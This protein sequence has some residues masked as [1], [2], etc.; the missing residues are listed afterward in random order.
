MDGPN[1][2]PRWVSNSRV[3]L[4]PQNMDTNTHKQQHKRQRTCETE[5]DLELEYGEFW[6]RF[7]VISAAD[8]SSPLR[9][10]PFAVQKGIEGA[11]GKPVNIRKLQSGDLVVEV[12]RKSH[13]MNLLKLPEFVGHKVKCT[14]HMSL[15]YSK[16]ILRCR[17]LADCSEDE[18]L[19]EL[20]SQGVTQLKR[21]STKRD[22]VEVKTN[23]YLL[24]FCT[25]TLPDYVKIGYLNCRLQKYVPNPQR[26]FKCQRYGHTEMR[27]RHE[28]VCGKCGENGH[29]REQCQRETKCVHCGGN[30]PA[31]SRDCQKWKEEKEILTLKT[32]LGITFPE[33]R[34]KYFDR[35]AEAERSI[36]HQQSYSQVVKAISTQTIETQTDITWVKGEQSMTVP[37]SSK[38]S[39]EIVPSALTKKVTKSSATQ[40]SSNVNI[41][42][43]KSDNAGK[44]EQAT[45]AKANSQRVPKAEKPLEVS[46]NPIRDLDN[47]SKVKK[48]VKLKRNNGKSK[49][50]NQ[51]QDNKFSAL[52]SE[53]DVASSES[54]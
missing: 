22:G 42:T 33:A 17:D 13:A 9:L 21:F 11:A 50:K 16:G 14:P 26:C 52:D 24:T 7:I 34:R 10:S 29:G 30:H 45:K 44:S 18:I 43:Y 39:K 28:R 15:N 46:D 31:G 4:K 6:P 27:C 54:E 23:T 1:W 41:K 12:D 19:S 25:S 40:A 49:Q 53:M 51:T 8:P 38:N 37:S 20:R 35:I 47:D 3:N 5:P 32:D 36:T 48:C 2:A